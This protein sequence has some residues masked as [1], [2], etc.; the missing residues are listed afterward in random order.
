MRSRSIL[1]SI[2]IIVIYVTYIDGNNYCWNSAKEG[3]PTSTEK[4]DEAH[5][6]GQSQEMITRAIMSHIYRW[7]RLSNNDSI[8]GLWTKEKKLHPIFVP[9]P[10]L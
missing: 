1:L 7:S 10:H 5:N 6:N 3:Q 4:A 9:Q 8:I 2:V